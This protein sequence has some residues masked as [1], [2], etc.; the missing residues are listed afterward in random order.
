[1]TENNENSA[2]SMFNITKD[3]SLCCVSWL[4]FY[5]YEETTWVNQ[6]IKE[7]IWDSLTVSDVSSWSL[8]QGVWSQANKQSDGAVSENLHLLCMTETMNVTGPVM[9]SEASKPTLRCKPSPVRPH[10]LDLPKLGT[11]SSL[12]FGPSTGSQVMTWSYECLALA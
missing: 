8:S 10:L 5:C 11:S 3:V 2:E 12:S 4:P 9:C 7:T 6:L 1:M